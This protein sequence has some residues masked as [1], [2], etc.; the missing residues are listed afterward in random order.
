[1]G[2]Q[3]VEY[4]DDLIRAIDKE[5]GW[6]EKDGSSPSKTARDKGM[7]CK[8][9]DGPFGSTAWGNPNGVWSVCILAGI[10]TTLLAKSF[11]AL[12]RLYQKLRERQKDNR[13]W[14]PYYSELWHKRYL[15][16]C[17]TKKQSCD[18]QLCRVSRNKV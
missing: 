11:P 9:M 5:M 6:V 10:E 2:K 13:D 3:I 17:C 1:M 7:H 8:F 14:K 4:D 18:C 16:W 15:R 12:E